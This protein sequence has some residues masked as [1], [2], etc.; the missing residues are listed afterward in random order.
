MSSELKCHENQ[1]FKWAEI[2]YWH[3]LRQ[4]SQWLVATFCTSMGLVFAHT[5]CST[6]KSGVQY[7]HIQDPG[8]VLSLPN[9]AVPRAQIY[10]HL[11]KSGIIPVLKDPGCRKNAS[12]KIIVQLLY[13]SYK[14]S[15]ST[16]S[17]QWLQIQ[18]FQNCKNWQSFFKW[19]TVH[20]PTV[21]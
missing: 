20:N 5:E 2:I 14:L 16:H 4:K 7:F 1:N 12:I 15:T 10:S 18:K 13:S 8:A 9:N 3:I 6:S 17:A 19:S 21:M 11:V